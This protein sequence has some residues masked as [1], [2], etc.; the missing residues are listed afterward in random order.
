M[1]D[2]TWVHAFTDGRDVSPTAAAADLAELPR[3]RI[4]T[5]CGRYYAMDRDKRWERTDR[6][7]AAILHGAGDARR[8]RSPP[9][10]ELRAR[11]HRRVHR[12]DRDR[13]PPAARSGDGRGDLLQLPARTALASSRSGCS[14]RAST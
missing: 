1:A 5:I 4:A 2:R 12:A 3:R 9:S 7:L 10:R 8:T 14:R 6:A 13:R 11:R